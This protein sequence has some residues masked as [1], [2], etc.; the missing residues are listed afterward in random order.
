MSKFEVGDEVIIQEDLCVTTIGPTNINKGMLEYAGRATKVTD[1]VPNAYA[2][3]YSLE[4]IHS[5]WPEE[6]LSPVANPLEWD[7]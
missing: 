5:W 2:T 6:L 1:K 7:I 3:N 4:G